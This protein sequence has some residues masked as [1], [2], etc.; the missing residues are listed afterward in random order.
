MEIYVAA[1]I[2]YTK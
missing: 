2:K 1:E